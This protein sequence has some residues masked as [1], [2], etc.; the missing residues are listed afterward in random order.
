MTDTAAPPQP[1]GTLTMPLWRAAIYVAASLLLG[2]SQ[3]LGM[4]LFSSNVAQL[5]GEFAATQQEVVWLVAAYLAPAALTLALVKIRT[6][7][8]LRRFGEI[9]LAVFVASALLNFLANDLASGIAVRFISGMA[10]APIATLA[11]LYAIE[12]FTPA[13]KLS[14]GL[15]LALIGIS[16]GLPM[17]RV[18]SPTLLDLG[19]WHQLTL[20]E[21]ALALVCFCVVLALP[22]TPVP[23]EKVIE[24]LDFI[25]FPLIFF[26]LG[27]LAIALTVGKAYWWFTQDWLG[28]T[29]AGS[30]ACLAVA[31][32]IE[33]N[34]ESPLL[35]LRWIFSPTILQFAGALLVFRIVLAEQSSGAPGLFQ[36]AGLQNAQ[37]QTM[38]WMI[39]GATVLGGIVSAM[40]LKPGREHG[41]HAVALLLII[42]GAT[43]DAHATNLTRPAQMLFS[44]SLIAFASA[45]FLPAALAAGMMAALKKGPKYILNFIIIFLVTQKIGG[46][47]GSAV[48]QTIIQFRQNF[49]TAHLAADMALTDPLVIQRLQAYASVWSHATAD[50]TFARAHGTAQLAQVVQREATVLAYNDVFALIAL[51]AAAALAV[52]LAHWAL[53]EFKKRRTVGAGTTG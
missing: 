7:F 43:L 44:Q 16:L 36:A 3:G 31:A 11:F 35:D 17:S 4:S 2:L 24:R 30:V 19:G 1:T 10:A 5:Q 41:I 33:L 18:L 25:S 29:I 40:I 28:L 15:S 47:L 49:H 6:Q 46:S 42:V 48:F 9:G 23:H 12:P 50:A 34:R 22:L 21:L 45:L 8:G 13:K 26:G 51:V 32:V 20:L 37:M 27:G 53:I 39:A 14:I 52:L 38:F